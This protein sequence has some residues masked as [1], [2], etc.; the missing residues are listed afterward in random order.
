MR[1]LIPLLLTISLFS[2][3]AFAYGPRGHQLVGAIADKRLAR[4]R[5]VARKVRNLLDGLTLERAATLPDE[6]KSWDDC[7]GPGSTRDVI[8]KQRINDELRAFWQANKCGKTPSHDIFHY[9][10]VPVTGDE[11]Y[12]GG[13]I[14][15]DDFDVVQMIPFCIKVLRGEEPET[16]ERAITKSVAVILLAHYLG[17]I[18]QPLHVGAEFFN[19]D[20]D[21]FHPTDNDKGFEDQGG[22]KLILYTFMDGELRSAGKFHGYWDGQT[23]T[24]AF[25]DASNATVAQRLATRSPGAWKL[26]GDTETWAEQ[27]AND[28]LPL[29]R[30]AHSRLTYEHVVII[31]GAKEIKSGDAKEK[32]RRGGQFYA[33]WAAG[34]VKKEIHKGGWRL[35][36]LLEE[37][38]Q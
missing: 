31:D 20:G 37:T 32:R 26:T 10:D 24:N 9:T 8:S 3:N 33:I 36:A 2:V 22:N 23:V 15:R 18:H 14:G 1:K 7:R 21:A 5:A 11:D 12:D 19:A 30:E 29:A 35:A 38:L 4:N 27:M 28:I 13:T 16:N 25:G 6:I 34:V 17:D